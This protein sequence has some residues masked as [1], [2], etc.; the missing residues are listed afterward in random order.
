MPLHFPPNLIF[1]MLLTQPHYDE[2]HT[3]EFKQIL[4]AMP[5]KTSNPSPLT[6][7]E[8]SIHQKLP[9]MHRNMEKP[10]VPLVPALLA[11]SF[12]QYSLTRQF[13]SSC[14]HLPH[15][16]HVVLSSLSG[17]CAALCPRFLQQ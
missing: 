12:L 2:I 11:I 15:Q 9:S 13:S 5:N 16:S 10:K 6:V 3:N 8:K 4:H 14:P 7:N 1:P 17:H